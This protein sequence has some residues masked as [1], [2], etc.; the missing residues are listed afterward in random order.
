VK[1][2]LVLW[3]QLLEE[4]EKNDEKTAIHDNDLCV[5]GEAGILTSRKR[6]DKIVKIRSFMRWF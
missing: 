2:L 4:A 5:E 6:M 1:Q 3:Y